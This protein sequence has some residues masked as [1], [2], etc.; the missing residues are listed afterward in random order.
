VL[1]LP[2]SILRSSVDLAQAGFRPLKRIAIHQQGMGNN[3]KFQ[4]QFADRLWRRLGHNG[5]SFGD[6]GY[7]CTWEVTRGQ[8]GQ[9]GILVNYTGGDIALAMNQGTVEEKAQLFLGQIEPLLP[10]LAAQWNG[11]AALEYWPGNP[12]T[13]GSYSYWRTG[14]YTGFAGIEQ[15]PE[16]N[17]HFAGEHTSIDSQGYLNGAVESG[18]RAAEEVLRAL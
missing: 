4:L 2:F 9:S 18:E 3:V 14:Q 10:G 17:C 15:E 16:G 12:W 1:A 13:Q 7:Q 5:E 11:K 6:S 8:P